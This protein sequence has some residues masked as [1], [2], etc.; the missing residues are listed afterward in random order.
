M[1]IVITGAT[2]F[3]GRPLCARLASDGH[4]VTALSR[5]AD[6]ARSALGPSV[7]CV[8]W[9]GEASAGAGWMGAVSEADVVIHLAGQPV[10]EKAWTP[11]IKEALRRSR[12][13]TTRSLVD[14]MVRSERRPEAFICAS[15]INY[16]GD[17]GEEELTEASPPGRTFLAEL[18]VDW[19][20]EAAKAEPLGVRVV[21]HRAGIVLERGGAL[22][23][24]LFPLPAPVSPWYLG[25]GGP[26]GS[27]RQWF[28]WIHL[29]DA[30]EMF[31]WSAVDKRVSGAVNMVAPGMIRNIE[32][33]KSLGRALHRPAV[34]P[35]PP[36]VLKAIV[37]GFA[38]ELITSQRAR[39][40]AAEALGYEYRFPAIDDALKAIFPRQ[41]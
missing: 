27:G 36:F 30:V 21:R 22:E 2:G 16:Y 33:T 26:I 25:L 41:S 17:R 12:I 32:F 10:A 31:V 6:R 3:I 5:S 15:G 24:V 1:K 40:A 29:D 38:D 18:C 14:A 11:E 13:D 39:P 23:K 7:Q 20:Q 28:P 35:I 8:A 37:G 19:E 4:A 9:G 34:L